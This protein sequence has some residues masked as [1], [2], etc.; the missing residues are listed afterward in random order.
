MIDPVLIFFLSTLGF[1][2]TTFGIKKISNFIERRHLKKLIFKE[3]YK[4]NRKKLQE[5]KEKENEEC[6]ICYEDYKVKD[7]VL[8]LYCNHIYHRSCLKEWFKR[9]IKC[10][11]CNLPVKTGINGIRLNTIV[12]YLNE[13][14]HQ[15]LNHN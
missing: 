9:S 13:H 12:E 1:Y 7:K 11:L 15:Y 14:E 2:A 3:R 6:I 10:P 4:I 8:V 5:L